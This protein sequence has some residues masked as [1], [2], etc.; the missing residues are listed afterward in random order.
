MENLHK[1]KVSNITDAIIFIKTYR[2]F[3]KSSLKFGK[4]TIKTVVKDDYTAKHLCN[5]WAG[6]EKNFGSFFLNLDHSTQGDFIEFFGISVAGL[7][8]YTAKKEENPVATLWLSAPPTVE[9]LHELLKYFNNHS[10]DSFENLLLPNTNYQGDRYGN[11]TNWGIY[12]L[13]LQEENKY[14]V[15][16]QLYDILTKS[17]ETK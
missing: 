8:E 13:S 14:R 6:R 5:S 1:D 11:S 2:I 4:D 7:K 3:E 15:L 12:I 16:S 9:W 17:A 10:V